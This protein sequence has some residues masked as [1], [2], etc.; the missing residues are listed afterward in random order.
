MKNDTAEVVISVIVIVGF[1][2]LAVA[3]SDTMSER[4]AKCE[5]KGGEF[6]EAPVGYRSLCKLPNK[7]QQSF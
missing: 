2:V 4:Q 7:S 6:Y 1:I 3:A 5:A